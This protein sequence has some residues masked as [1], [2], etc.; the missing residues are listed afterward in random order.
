MSYAKYNNY[1]LTDM[2][3]KEGLKKLAGVLDRMGYAGRYKLY[4]DTGLITI[5]SVMSVLQ[6]AI[7]AAEAEAHG[8]LGHLVKIRRITEE[9]VW[10]PEAEAASRKDAYA[11]V[12][13]K[14]KSEPDA[15]K[16]TFQVSG[17]GM[18]RWL[19]DWE[20]QYLVD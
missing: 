3:S 16:Y 12:I 8:Q 1:F 2:I 7:I 19:E 9:T 10:V 11:V 13:N 20:V 4:E 6:R 18:D 5:N 14:A 15:G 17:S